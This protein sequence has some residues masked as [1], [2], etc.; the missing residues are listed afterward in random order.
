MK[1]RRDQI[2]KMTR[3]HLKKS[4]SLL[5]TIA[6]LSIVIAVGYASLLTATFSVYAATPSIAFFDFDIGSP[7]P[8]LYQG[9]PFNYTSDGVTARFSSPSDFPGSPT[10]SVQDSIPVGYNMSMFSGQWLY[11]NQ[12]IRD[13]LDIKF[14][15]HLYSINLTFAIVELHG[16]PGVEPSYINLTAYMNSIGNQVG[17]TWA[18]GETA[19]EQNTQGVLSFDSGGQPFN[20]DRKSVV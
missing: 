18:P 6:V 8:S 13:Y 7:P 10:F 2:A 5:A 9:T 1:I 20:L 19:S 11:D 12:P 4:R 14:D 15:A 16:G 3:T 17:W